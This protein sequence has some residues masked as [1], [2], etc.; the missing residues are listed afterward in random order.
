[1]PARFVYR[2]RLA[3]QIERQAAQHGVAELLD[4]GGQVPRPEALAL[5][6]KADAL[7]LLSIA[8]PS[9]ADI[10]LR[11]GLYPGKVFEY[12][13]AG[14]PILCVPGDGAMLDE[15]LAATRTGTVA[16]DAVAV[17]AFLTQAETARQNGGLAYA[18]DAGEVAQYTRRNL[19]R[20]LAAILDEV[21]NLR[22]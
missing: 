1:M 3:E 11:R 2:G 21:T 5:M 16:R 18:P 9:E 7:L 17:A 19:T 22:G 8:N 6:Q 14:K 13:G 15:L 4:S 10:F 20:R 12:F